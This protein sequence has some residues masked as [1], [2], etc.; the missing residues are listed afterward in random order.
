VE[1]EGRGLEEGGTGAETISRGVF[2][3]VD[4]WTA[5]YLLR[6]GWTGTY[7][8]RLDGMARQH[9]ILVSR[10]RLR[11]SQ[12]INELLLMNYLMELLFVLL[13]TSLT[14]AVK[15]L[16]A[17]EENPWGYSDMCRWR[18]ESKGNIQT[19]VGKLTLA[20]QPRYA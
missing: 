7:I 17:R 14:W 16:A 11:F 2:R 9:V 15:R 1:S 18:R 12:S 3:C 6:C 19:R 20:R 4:G 5:G 8:Q 13:S 10:L